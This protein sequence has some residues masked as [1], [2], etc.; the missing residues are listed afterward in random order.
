MRDVMHMVEPSERERTRRGGSFPFNFDMVV[1]GDT[2]VESENDD[3]GDPNVRQVA[4]ISGLAGAAFPL[5][6]V[7]SRPSV[8]LQLGD[9]KHEND[10]SVDR[11]AAMFR[12]PL[13]DGN[14]DTN[15]VRDLITARM[16]SLTWG[17]NWGGVWFQAMTENFVALGNTTPPTVEQIEGPVAASVNARPIDEPLMFVVH[18]ALSG[19][20]GNPPTAGYLTEWDPAALDAL[21]ALANSRR[22]VGILFGHDHYTHRLTW[23]GIRCFSPGSVRMSPAV[24]VY[25]TIYPENFLVLRLRGDHYEVG[26]YC[27][28]FDLNRPLSGGVVGGTGWGPG[29]WEWAERVNY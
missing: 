7:L 14:H 27:F 16:G 18:R 8:V 6:G 2:H 22:T 21:E 19:T 3:A 24:P 4:A 1:V 25:S 13:I 11:A 28:G 29:V 26:S 15:D 23:R 9:F 17:R 5:G 12:G 10:G 20:D